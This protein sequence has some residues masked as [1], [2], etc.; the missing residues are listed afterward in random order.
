MIT[1]LETSCSNS[2]KSI[3]ECT[4]RMGIVLDKQLTKRKKMK[5]ATRIL[6]LGVELSFCAGIEETF[7]QG[8]PCT[9]N[10]RIEKVEIGKFPLIM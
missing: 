7:E 5:L 9:T 1:P 4:T 10:M 8:N 2:L 3:V 6:R